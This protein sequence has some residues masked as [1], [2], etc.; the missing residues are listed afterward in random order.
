MVPSWVDPTSSATGLR[1]R[2]LVP[3]SAGVPHRQHAQDDGG[4]PQR[5]VEAVG[6]GSRVGQRPRRRSQRPYDG[7]EGSPGREPTPRTGRNQHDGTRQTKA[8]QQHVHGHL[9]AM[10]PARY[11]PPKKMRPAAG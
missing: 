5:D 1:R 3:G 7:K 2:L 8:A 10:R 9:G 11:A 6:A 4:D